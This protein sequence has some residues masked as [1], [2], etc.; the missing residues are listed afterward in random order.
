LIRVLRFLTGLRILRLMIFPQ[1]R[2]QNKRSFSFRL[3][4][5][6]RFITISGN[7][8]LL[9]LKLVAI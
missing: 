5:T 1:R 4:E 3:V 9:V 7:K 2:V 6:K 8:R